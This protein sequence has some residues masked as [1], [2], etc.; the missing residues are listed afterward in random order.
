MRI[1]HTQ[2]FGFEAAILRAMRKPLKSH[3]KADSKIMT[4]EIESVLWGDTNANT[5]GFILGEKDG[6][7]SR[8]LTRAGDS[9]SKHLRQI[10]VWFDLTLP[11]FMWQEFDTYRHVEKV[12]E[13]TMHTLLKDDLSEQDFEGNMEFT[14][15]DTLEHLIELAL[16]WK[17]TEDYDEKNLLH[18][19]AKNNLPESF[20]QTRSVCTNYQCLKNM[21]LQ[22]LPHKL[23]Q[24]HEILNWILILP[25][26]KE[27]T[28]IN[29]FEEAEK[30]PMI[31]AISGKAEHGKDTFGKILKDK[32]G[33]KACIL[34]FADYVKHVATMIYNWDGKKDEYGRTLLQSIGA[35]VRKKDKNFWVNTVLN[36][37]NV[38][39]SEFDYFII[40]DTRYVN[41]IELPKMERINTVSV[42]VNRPLFENSLTEEQRN[43]ESEVSLDDYQFDETYIMGEGLEFVERAVDVFMEDVIND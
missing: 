22:R 31:I 43:H 18:Y 15:P 32:L 30:L 6:K 9:H 1:E 11:R 12:S 2:V 41:E 17:K 36:L 28:G 42:R 25:Y 40:P 23:K 19:T 21:Y 26:F 37:I 5:E 14:N 20:L 38:L 10:I 34:H 35:G 16:A 7:L 24:W 8:N 29:F 13:S 3:G 27:L 4:N 39:K 33:E